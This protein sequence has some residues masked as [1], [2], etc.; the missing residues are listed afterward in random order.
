MPKLIEEL[1][2]L[3]NNNPDS[4][5]AK[6]A[7]TELDALNIVENRKRARLQLGLNWILALF[8]ITNVIIGILSFQMKKS[9]QQAYNQLKVELNKM[10]EMER[11]F[12]IRLDAMQSKL[13]SV[14]IKTTE[15]T[16]PTE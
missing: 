1:V 11:K 7:K 9:E 15:L 16:N 6:R 4:D 13:D 2:E 14:A 3:I 10:V 8:T 12:Y 5:R